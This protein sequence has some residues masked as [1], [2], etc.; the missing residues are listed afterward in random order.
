MAYKEFCREMHEPPVNIL[1]AVP[2]YVG[3]ESDITLASNCE[4]HL[5]GNI[6]GNVNGHS[7]DNSHGSIHDNTHGSNY[8]SSHDNVHGN[9]HENVQHNID[10]NIYHEIDL[11]KSLKNGLYNKNT[12]IQDDRHRIDTKIKIRKGGGKYFKHSLNHNRMGKLGLELGLDVGVEAD[13]LR[14]FDMSSGG[15]GSGSGSR[16]GYSPHGSGEES[17]DGKYPY[18]LMSGLH[19]YTVIAVCM[20]LISAFAAGAASTRM[21]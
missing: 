17:Q 18:R 14:I 6:H 19:N 4:R 16:S 5:D 8:D 2:L 9:I 3:G 21:S 13:R 10:G 1:T 7:N 15:S 20:T 11:S 12:R